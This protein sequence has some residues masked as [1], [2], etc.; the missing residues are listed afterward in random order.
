MTARTY[1]AIELVDDAQGTRHARWRITEV[2]PHVAIRLKQM[3]ARIPKTARPPFDLSGGPSLDADLRWFLSRYPMRISAEHRARL[4]ARTTLFEDGQ[5]EL[6]TILS[7]N[8]QPPDA[9]GFKDGTEPYDY[10]MQAAELT[11]RTGRLLLMDEM[12]L[13]KLQPVSEPVL[14]PQGWRPI[15]DL[16]VGDPIIGRD[17]G[18]HLVTG[19]F[20]QGIRAVFRV[21]L[22]DGSWTR[23]GDE[24]LWAV[25]D[26]NALHRGRDWSPKVHEQCTA[27]LDRPG[28]AH[29]VDSIFLVS[30]SGSDPAITGVLGI[31]SS[32]AEGIV[33]PLAE[34][35]PQQVDMSRIQRMAE[36][37]LKSKTVD[38]AV[39]PVAP[40]RPDV[41]S[42]RVGQQMGLL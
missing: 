32:Q 40:A 28:Q 30:D 33:D 4:E 3:F 41:Q 36:M 1:G 35:T 10:Q 5:K 6:G 15:G 29:Q 22:T 34:R 23:A 11:R 13:G 25:K 27:R 17:G 12:G 21:T 20:P 24:H 18:V 37:Y 26:D 16:R 9:V 19:V 39:R 7:P 42:L 2:E 14:T 31:K 8:W 38:G